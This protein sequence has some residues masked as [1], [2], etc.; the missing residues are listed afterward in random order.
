M[1]LTTL[2]ETSVP[3]KLIAWTDRFARPEWRGAIVEGW[4]FEG[5]VARR[6]AEERLRELGVQ[7][8]IRSAYK[9]LLHHFLEDV[10]RDQLASVTVR[11]PVH[12]RALPGRFML[13]A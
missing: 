5:A 4:L 3:R 2:L 8:R 1:P 6:G 9:P 13:E 11:Y 12:P 7:A 10:A